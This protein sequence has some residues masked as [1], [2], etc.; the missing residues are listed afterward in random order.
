LECENVTG[1]KTGRHTAQFFQAAEEQAC[2]G[3]QGDG[4][5]YLYSHERELHAVASGNLSAT[6]V[7]HRT[8]KVPASSSKRGQQA[9]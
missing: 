2:T 9:A 1:I 6:G 7:S 8:G 3:E 4:E 5:R